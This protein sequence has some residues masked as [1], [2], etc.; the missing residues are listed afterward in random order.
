MISK[1]G[2]QKGAR[3]YALY[4]GIELVEYDNLPKFHQIVANKLAKVCLPTVST[5]GQP[6]YVIM[7]KLNDMSTT[8]NYYQYGDII[9]LFFCKRAAED[10]RRMFPDKNKWSTYGV[11]KEQLGF[12]CSI[13]TIDRKM[14]IGIVPFLDLRGDEKWFAIAYPVELIREAFL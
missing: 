11:S 14:K 8:G 9:P 6:F 10:A 12:L 1:N 2:Y 5:L 3:E 13:H 4:E 7:E